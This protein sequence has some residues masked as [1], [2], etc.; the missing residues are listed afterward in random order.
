MAKFRQV[1]VEF[2]EDI[3]V[4]GMTP[5]DKLFYLYLLTNP[6]TTQI[7]VYQITKKR[8]AFE[9]GYSMEALEGLFKRFIDHHNVIRYNEQTHEIAIKNWGKY[10]LNR[11]GKPVEDCIKR[12]LPDVKDTDLI[13]YVAQ[14]I[15]EESKVKYLFEAYLAEGSDSFHDTGDESDD[16]PSDDSY[17]DTGDDE[18]GRTN[19]EEGINNKNK[20]KSDD[21]SRSRSKEY[22]TSS[23]YYQMAER[24]YQK[25]L[26]NNPEHKKPNFQ[27]WAD[28]FRKL[29]E[30]DKKKPDVV[31]KMIDWV[32]KHEFWHVNILSPDKLRK[33]WDKLKMEVVRE[34][35]GGRG[36]GVH[37][38][39]A[40]KDKDFSS[41]RQHLLG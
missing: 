14:Q 19:K 22:D 12:E 26:E 20:K 21:S 28:D 5:E 18:G 8:M 13:A 15:P 4:E 3:T 1:Y 11:G 36:H 41:G 17:N 34:S 29:V 40:G 24:L 35:K 10:N 16:E 9:L 23:L 30:L 38:E 37:E 7:G 33:Q 2:W 31:F 27:K 25:I 6:S 32:Q 39:S